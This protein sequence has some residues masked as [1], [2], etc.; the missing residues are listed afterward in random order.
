MAVGDF[1]LTRF[2]RLIAEFDHFATIEANKVIVMVL[3]G[4]F[5]NRFTAFEV[6]T[7]HN[8]SIIKLV[9]H[10]INSSET[11]FFTHV[12]QALV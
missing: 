6:V 4:Q 5:E 2:D 11:N 9:Q 1:T 12:D 8:A 10:A 3:L 7:S